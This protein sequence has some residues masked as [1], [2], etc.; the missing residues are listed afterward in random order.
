MDNA[1]KAIMIGVGLFI[2]I[3]IIS[4][5]LLI[6]NLGTGLIGGAQTQLGTMSTSLQNQVLSSYD[7]KTMSGSEVLAAA[8][9]YEKST[10]VA[11]VIYNGAQTGTTITTTDS[12]YYLGRGK[13][14][15]SPNAI[16]VVGGIET[17]TTTTSGLTAV[18]DNYTSV[19]AVLNVRGTYRCSYVTEKVTGNVIGIAFIQAGTNTP[20]RATATK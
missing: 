10:E 12:A 6:T 3:I 13:I 1:Q 19:A 4:A 11:V 8:R 16:G 18:T 2:T 7:G 17:T 14:D 5:V 9:Q 20:A 15:V